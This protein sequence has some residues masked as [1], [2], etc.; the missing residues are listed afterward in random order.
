MKPATESFCFY[1]NN[2]TS[3]FFTLQGHSQAL[4]RFPPVLFLYLQ[5]LFSSKPILSQFQARFGVCHHVGRQEGSVRGCQRSRG[6]GVGQLCRQW[7]QQSS[8]LIFSPGRCS[9]FNTVLCL[10]VFLLICVSKRFN[11]KDLGCNWVLHALFLICDRNPDVGVSYCC[12][13]VVEKIFRE[14]LFLWPS[15]VMNHY[16]VVARLS[17][18]VFFAD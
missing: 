14:F 8:G 1:R 4:L 12:G 18:L 6:R 11:L 7:A 16:V 17:V 5:I 15:G 10:L 2:N 3:P 9:I 13:F